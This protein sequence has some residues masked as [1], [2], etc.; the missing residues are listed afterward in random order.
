M[1][2]TTI[3]TRTLTT[4]TVSAFDLVHDEY[5]KGLAFAFN[6]DGTYSVSGIVTCTDTDIKIPSVYNGEKV[7]SIGDCAFRWC[8]DLTSISIPNSV[9]SISWYGFS[10]CRSL[11]SIV[12]P[13]GITEIA[14]YAFSECSSL[15]DIYLPNGLRKIGAGAFYGCVSLTSI[16]IPDRVDE[17]CYSA[18]AKCSGLTNI[19]IPKNATIGFQAFHGIQEIIKK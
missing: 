9:K 10:G 13:N 12:L 18:F 3:F 2:T 11:T 1:K 5:S 8:T 17:I 6:E 19:A 15:I 4:S 7:T 16:T 14:R